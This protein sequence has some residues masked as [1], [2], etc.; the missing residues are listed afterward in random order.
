M[1]DPGGTEPRELSTCPS[2]IPAGTVTSA[3]RCQSLLFP[4]HCILLPGSCPSIVARWHR[5]NA[6]QQYWWAQSNPS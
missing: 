5:W 2:F 4:R 3:G 6:V 1:C